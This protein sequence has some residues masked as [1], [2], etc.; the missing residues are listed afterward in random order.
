MLHDIHRNRR[1]DTCANIPKVRV[2][3]DLDLGQHPIGFVRE[4]SREQGENE[5][6]APAGGADRAASRDSRTKRSSCR[7]RQGSGIFRF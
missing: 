1:G 6:D 3:V 2:C 5:A 7:T 4:V